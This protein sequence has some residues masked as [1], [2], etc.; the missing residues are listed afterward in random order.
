[1][2]FGFF[3]YLEF[4]EK[5][6]DDWFGR[7]RLIPSSFVNYLIIKRARPLVNIFTSSS[8]RLCKIVNKV[9]AKFTVEI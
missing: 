9:V 4:K 7:Q 3:I 5:P 8:L 1:M 6:Y 2:L